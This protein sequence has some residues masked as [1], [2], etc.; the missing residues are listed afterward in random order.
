MANLWPQTDF[1]N[2]KHCIL[3]NNGSKHII[4]S[5]LSEI[6][7]GRELNLKKSTRLEKQKKMKMM[8]NFK[9]LNY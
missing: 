7:Q 5:Q 9:Q 6:S 1:S 2:S 4:T 3:N 8:L